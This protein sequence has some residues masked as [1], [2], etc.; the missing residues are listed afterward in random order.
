MQVR[1]LSLCQMLAS[2][3]QTVKTRCFSS[4][5]KVNTWQVNSGS[6]GQLCSLETESVSSPLLAVQHAPHPSIIWRWANSS[7]TD[8]QKS[9]CPCWIHHAWSNQP[10]ISS[11]TEF[12]TVVICGCELDKCLFM[13]NWMVGFSNNWIVGLIAIKHFF[14]DAS[15]CC[16]LEPQKPK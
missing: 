8:W 13:G 5:W 7:V 10:N 1:Y 14:P 16:R 3:K 4:P 9:N 12:K 6:V 15:I 11:S 2:S